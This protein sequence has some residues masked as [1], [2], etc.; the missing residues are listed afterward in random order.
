VASRGGCRVKVR[1]RWFHQHV[2]YNRGP[3]LIVILCRSLST[4][5]SVIV[6]CCRGSGQHGGR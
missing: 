4:V 2:S 1:C 6:D 3:R 5:I